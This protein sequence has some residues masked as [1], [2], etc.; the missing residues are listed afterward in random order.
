[1]TLRRMTTIALIL[2]VAC[3]AAPAPVALAGGADPHPLQAAH[4]TGRSRGTSD[5]AGSTGFHWTDAGIGAAAGF[6]LAT[7]AAATLALIRTRETL[8][9]H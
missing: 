4:H 2:A 1:M 5:V 6:G 3:L 9:T 8:E 7:I